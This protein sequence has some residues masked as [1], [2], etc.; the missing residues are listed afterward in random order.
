MTGWFRDARYALRQLSKAPVFTLTAI[1]TLALGIGANS[2]IFSWMNSTLFS[3]VPGA[4]PQGD[5][6][7]LGRGEDNYFSYP[8]YLDLRDHAHTLAGLISWYIGPLDL[9]GQGKP[10]RLWAALTTANYFDALGVRPLKGRFFEP[11]EGQKP[12]GAPVAVLSYRTWQLLFE[13]DP[14]IVGRTINLNQHPYTVIGVAPPLFQGATAGLRMDLW[15]PFMMDQQLHSAHDAVHDRADDAL[16]VM[17][18]LASGIT[19]EQAQQDL[20]VEMQQIARA[21]PQEH[22]GRNNIVGYPMWRAPGGANQYLHTMLPPLMAIALVVLLLAGVNVANLFLVRAVARRREM[23]VRLSLG[24]NRG[25]LVRQLLVES[26]LVALAGGGLAMIITTWSARSFERFIPQADLP[27]ALNMH[28][29]GRVLGV[30]FLLST[31]TGIAF[32]LLPA[33]RSSQI[34][35]VAVLKEEAG[36]A[37]GGRHKARLTSAL[38]VVQI[39]LSFLL[40]V[41]GGLFL[42]GFRNAQYADPGFRADHVLLSSIDLFPAGYTGDTG[43]AFQRELLHR[44]EQIPGVQSATLADW[45]PLGFTDDTDL[46]TPEG[47]AP[48]RNESL[49]MPEMHVGPNYLRTLQIPLVAG[50]DI[51]EGDNQGSQRVAVVNEKFGQQ[52]WPG[53]NAIGRRIKIES[54]WYTVVGI[55]KN[56]KYEELDEPTRPFV[57][58]PA[59]QNSI[60][61]VVLHVLVSGDPKAYTAQVEKAVHGLNGDLPVLDEYPLTRNVEIASTGTRV[62]GTFAG[63][64]GLVGLALAAIGIYGVIAYSTRQRIHEIGIRMALGAKRRDVFELV[65]K[66]GLRLT[67]IGMVAGILCALV[68]TPFLRSQL[69]GVA[70]T[71]VLTYFGVAIV[72]LVVALAACFL[73][74]QRAAGVDPI[75]V[76][77]YE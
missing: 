60:H 33:L 62:A 5:L 49:E 26:V 69:Y 51:N 50:R 76:L 54:N 39:T 75:R 9:T 74:A 67:A 28:V 72:L 45:S 17:G 34:V 16:S 23:A 44:L 66:Q 8:D 29:D 6:I 68:L 10:Q 52:Y 11:E 73:P 38:V 58:W 32:G 14:N 18:V 15:A 25:R 37:S 2:T 64:F 57:Y 46:I 7:A 27:I 36:T 63:M 70:P 20:T 43:I 24:A 41:C 22:Q 3:P 77:R 35:P 56:A 4:N 48:Q 31:L 1:V 71:D 55:A 21:Y 53:Q 65:L 19:R 40:L 42:R 59:F 13:G 61:Q 47:Y 12:G 30:T